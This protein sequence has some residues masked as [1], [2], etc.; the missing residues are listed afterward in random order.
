MQCYGIM[1]KKHRLWSW[2]LY[3]CI[4]YN[5]EDG[6]DLYGLSS[7]TIIVEHGIFW[8]SRGCPQGS[9]LEFVCGLLFPA[10]NFWTLPSWRRI[11]SVCY[12]STQCSELLL[13]LQSSLA[14]LCPCCQPLWIF[15][16]HVLS[17]FQ[18]LRLAF[19]NVFSSNQATWSFLIDS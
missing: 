16:C 8:I 11:Q 9:L 17:P 18:L 1:R 14:S 12:F 13:H 7:L 4:T 5:T 6:N 3:P 19:P 15:W 10:L 2:I